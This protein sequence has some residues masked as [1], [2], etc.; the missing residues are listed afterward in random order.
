V[1]LH[2]RNDRVIRRRLLGLEEAG[3]VQAAT[4]VFGRGRGRPEKLFSLAHEGVALV[5]EDTG[6][7][8]EVPT[9]RLTAARL[10]CL[11]HQLLVNWF[12]IH[13]VQMSRIVPRLEV[14]FLS[15]TS[16]F[17]A[18]SADGRPMIFDVVPQAEALDEMV[19][20]TPDGVFSIRDKEQ[21]KTLLFFLEADRGTETIVSPSGAP[22]DIRQKVINYQTYFGTEGYKRYEG[23][24]KCTL[25]GFRLL[26][27]SC[28]DS[29]LANLC[30]LVRETPPSDFIWLTD[31][32]HMYYV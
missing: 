23:T 15:P 26:F 5:R 10:T 28:S 18:P 6:L 21:D 12:R 25:N 13:L 3:L 9:D 29:R 30:R 16:P 1:A 11:E 17:L 27:L 24:W 8:A 2:P 32:S 7:G 22:S 14:Q 20:F 31:Q 19:G 4:R